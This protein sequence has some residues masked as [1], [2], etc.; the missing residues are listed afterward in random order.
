MECV[1][2]DTLGA[3]APFSKTQP[4]SFV[5]FNNYF[6]KEQKSKLAKEEKLANLRK[7][8]AIQKKIISL[9]PVVHAVVFF[10]LFKVKENLIREK[11]RS[12]VL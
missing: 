4:D 5:G 8:R 1:T 11:C 12:K 9:L 10:F 3:K 2:L 7:T 6:T